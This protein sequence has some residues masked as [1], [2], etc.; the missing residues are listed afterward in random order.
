M[1][2]DFVQYSGGNNGIIRKT[3]IAALLK[4]HGA[5]HTPSPLMAVAIKTEIQK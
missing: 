3:I 4:A 5:G 1:P 2:G